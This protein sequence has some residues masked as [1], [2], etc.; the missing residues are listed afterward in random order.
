MTM[1]RDDEALITRLLTAP[2]DDVL[3]EARM[4][5]DTRFGAL[6]PA[7]MTYSRKVF[8]PLTRLCADVCHYCT[9]ATTPSRLHAPYLTE[10]EVLEIAR[11]GLAAGCKEALFTL[12]DA[13]ERRYAAA[14]EWLE[15]RGF[16]RTVDYV[17]HCAQRVLE[18]TGLLPHI[19]AGVLEEA[20]WRMLRPVAASVGLM[21]ESTSERLLDKGMCHHG[22]PDKVPAVRLASLAAAGRARVPTTSGVLIGIGETPRERIE[23]LIALRDLHEAHGHEDVRRHRGERSGFPAHHRRRAD[24]AAGRSLGAGT[25]QPQ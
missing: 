23:A 21:L 12:G 5:R 8:I 22:S 1:A 2:L 24:R 7:R 6:T 18:E 4:R 16:T 19:N 14:R 20:D 15:E 11:A 10:E 25:A 9:F 17:R 3:A 13:P